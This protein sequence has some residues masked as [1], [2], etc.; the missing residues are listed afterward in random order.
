MLLVL[1]LAL[2][3]GVLRLCGVLPLLPAS[4]DRDFLIDNILV[5]THFI[6]EMI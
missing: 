3:S 2:L 1:L 6:I 5:R 4:R